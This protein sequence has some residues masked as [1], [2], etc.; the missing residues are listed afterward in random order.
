MPILHFNKAFKIAQ[1][2]KVFLDL[3]SGVT[4]GKVPN[5]DWYEQQVKQ[6][7]IARQKD[8]Q[9]IRQQRK[10]IKELSKALVYAQRRKN[11]NSKTSAHKNQ[12]IFREIPPDIPR[13]IVRPQGGLANRMRVITSFQILARYSGRVYEL[14]WVPS[15]GWSDED[16][17]LLFENDYPR[18]SRDEFKRYRR[19]GLDLQKAVR[20]MNLDDPASERAWKWREGSGMHQVFDSVTFP[21]V[22]YAGNLRCDWLL[23]PARRAR[24]FP[25]FES[26]FRA[27][28]TEWSPVPSI[29][30]EVERLTASFGPNTVGVHIRRGDA[31]EQHPTLTATGTLAVASEFRGSTDAAFIAQM[32]AELAAEPHTNFFLATDSA[33]TEKRFRER[34]GEAVMVNRDKTFVPSALGQ[35]KD[36]QRDAVID[37]FAL[38][39]TRKI[40]CNNYSSF[41]QMAADIGGIRSKT[42]LED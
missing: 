29:R 16:L 10:K 21:A 28:L 20:I 33:A 2:L 27:G 42:V 36:N 5:T 34:Y 17:S 14:C 35:P 6:L 4:R 31:W 1:N 41:S 32:D 39:R 25:N 18:V 24:L 12:Q 37:M 3:R 38:A 23:D 9:L 19:N 13:L 8:R 26:D 15:P 22:T 30:A 11:N 7:R 40:L